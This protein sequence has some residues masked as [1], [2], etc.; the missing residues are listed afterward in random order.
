VNLFAL[1][2]LLLSG[3]ML[4]LSL[5]PEVLRNIAKANPFAYAVDGAR[6][7]INGQ[8]SNA[9]VAQALIIF[10]VLAVLALTWATRSMRKATA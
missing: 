4:P 10:G 7:M 6:A 9:A 5:A 1:P 3:V 8:L 2:L